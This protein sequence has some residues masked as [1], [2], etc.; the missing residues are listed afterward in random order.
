MEITRHFEGKGWD[1]LGAGGAEPSAG[2]AVLDA[3]GAVLG[4]GNA[5]HC[6]AKQLFSKFT[7]RKKAKGP[8]YKYLEPLAA[9][10]SSQTTLG[11][12]L[13]ISFCYL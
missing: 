4:A 2:D 10:L 6:S 8:R 11:S 9:R 3:G 13:L 7:N 12:L 1:G 5:E